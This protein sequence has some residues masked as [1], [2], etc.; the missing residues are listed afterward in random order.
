M[1]ELC[2][3]RISEIVERTEVGEETS[4]VWAVIL[5][6]LRGGWLIV[7]RGRNGRGEVLTIRH[8]DSRS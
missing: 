6:R 7:G 4:D 3:A 8:R 5:G 2:C 1:C